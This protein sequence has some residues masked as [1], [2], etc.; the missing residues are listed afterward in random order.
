MET[1]L[2]FTLVDIFYYIIKD[3]P[4]TT[5]DRFLS[6]MKTF[7]IDKKRDIRGDQI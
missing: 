3:I 2:L 4:S 7:L 5:S 1:N 6:P